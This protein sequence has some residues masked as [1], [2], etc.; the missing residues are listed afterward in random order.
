MVR[1]ED[2]KQEFDLF[3]DIWKMF[4][5]LLPVGAKHDVEY[6]DQVN[7]KVIEIM[8]QYPGEFG[9][10]LSFAVLD[11]LDRRCNADENKDAGC[12]TVC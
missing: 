3:G 10:A 12:D 2:I 1:N 6:W 11:E 4:K 8:H 7:K 9:K 5:S